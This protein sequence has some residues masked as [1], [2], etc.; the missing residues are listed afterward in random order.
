MKDAI[1]SINIVLG[2]MVLMAAG[3]RSL[4]GVMLV[5]F[6]VFIVGIVLLVKKEA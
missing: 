3:M 6:M 2:L 1:G 5:G 4:D